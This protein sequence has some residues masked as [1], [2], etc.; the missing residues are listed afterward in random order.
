MSTV[1]WGQL[2]LVPMQRIFYFLVDPTL[3]NPPSP[4]DL[5]HASMVCRS[6]YEVAQ[7]DEF[8]MILTQG[9]FEF[10][11]LPLKPFRRRFYWP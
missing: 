7:M 1:D 10:L 4:I 11:K 2:P 6:W 9:Q 5:V 3:D 8:W